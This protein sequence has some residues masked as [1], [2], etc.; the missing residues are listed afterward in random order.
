MDKERQRKVFIAIIGL[1]ALV[2]I[3]KLFLT[4]DSGKHE[5]VTRTARPVKTMVL[6]G[7]KGDGSRFFPGRIVAAQQVDIAFRVA[8][9]LSLFPVFAGQQVEKGTLLAK[10][11]SRDYEINLTA[12]QSELG[13]ARAQLSSMRAGARPEDIAALTAQMT[14]AKAR[15]DEATS[16]YARVESLFAQK[17]IAQVELDSARTTLEAARTNYEVAKQELQKGK[18]GARAEDVQAMVFRIKGLEAQVAAARNMVKDSELR[19]PFKGIVAARYVENF[20]NVKKDEPIVSLQNLSEIEI[21]VNLPETVL[22]K[23]RQAG[24][25]KSEASFESLPGKTFPLTLKEVTTQ[26]DPQTQTYAAK[27][28]M[29]RPAGALLLPGMTAEVHFTLGTQPPAQDDEGRVLFAVPSTSVTPKSGE[30]Q[31]VWAVNEKTMTVHAIPVTVIGFEG[32]KTV[33]SGD[34]RVGTRIVVAGAN[35][36]QEG[37]LVSLFGETE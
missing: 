22:E 30:I 10:L 32:D 6:A 3:A 37:D 36:L 28:R 15:L 31:S 14:A 27:F 9:N 2:V 34:L 21:L 33:I 5:V 25:V 17:A 8:G 20:E 13:Y 35:F 12:A 29:E 1:A 7:E 19:A 4:G 24:N 23:A 16:T 18:S 11:D 26:S